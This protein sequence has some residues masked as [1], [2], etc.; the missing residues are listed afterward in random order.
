MQALDHTSSRMKG[1]PGRASCFNVGGLDPRWTDPIR[2][3]GGLVR[4]GLACCNG[5][6]DDYACSSRRVPMPVIDGLETN[7]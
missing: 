2:G 5:N 6:Y 4:G 1:P 3:G 7:T